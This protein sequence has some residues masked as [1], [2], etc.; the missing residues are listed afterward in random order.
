MR[1][2]YLS[3]E[4][5]DSYTFANQYVLWLPLHGWKDFVDIVFMPTRH[6]PQ[7]Y[8]NLFE[9]HPRVSVKES[10]H[11]LCKL[12]AHRKHEALLKES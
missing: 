4:D 9:L 12:P 3:Y 8:L 6:V 5:S 2:K 10:Q 7:G 1:I 11:M